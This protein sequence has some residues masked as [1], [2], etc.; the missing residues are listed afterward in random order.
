MQRPLYNINVPRLQDLISWKQT[1]RGLIG[2]AENLHSKLQPL[3][4]FGWDVTDSKPQ[5]GSQRLPSLPESL[6][7][8]FLLQLLSKG[9]RG[10][11]FTAVQGSS[12]CSLEIF[13]PFSG[14]REWGLI[15]LA[16]SLQ[17]AMRAPA[18][19]HPSPAWFGLEKEELQKDFSWVAE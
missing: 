3:G 15:P 1:Q 14:W 7:I 13:K 8:A 19:V 6:H 12:Y 18:Q 11:A 17:R 4:T 9:G 5:F 2:N 16:W 10:S